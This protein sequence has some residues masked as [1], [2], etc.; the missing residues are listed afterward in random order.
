MTVQGG[1]GGILIDA[2]FPK[3]KP[4]VV[5]LLY[6]LRETLGFKECLDNPLKESNI[7][8]IQECYLM[9]EFQ[10]NLLRGNKMLLQKQ[11]YDSY[12]HAPL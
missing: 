8:K 4:I 7:A 2:Y 3:S 5:G 1:G 12:S 11:Y 6:R 9:S 10:V